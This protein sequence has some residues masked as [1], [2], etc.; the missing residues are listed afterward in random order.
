MKKELQDQLKAYS[1]AASTV[2]ATGLTANAQIVYNSVNATIG[3]NDLDSVDFNMDGIYDFSMSVDSFSSYNVN[4]VYGA[5]LNSQGHALAGAQLGTS[6]TYYNYPFKLAAGDPIKTQ[7]F[8]SANSG[9]SFLFVYNGA[10]PFNSYWKG[11]VVDGYLGIKLNFGGN[12]H[13][14]WARMDIDASGTQ[15]VIKDVA[16]E[17]TPDKNINAG[18]NGLNLNKFALLAKKMWISNKSLF[19]DFDAELS[20]GQI[21]ICDMSGKVLK[22][23]M[24]SQGKNEYDVSDLP[25]GAYVL[26]FNTEDNSVN[27]KVVID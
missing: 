11:G 22:S 21:N 24:L 1:A 10:T 14:G 5:P 8:T 16:Y 13:Y 2:L 6:S 19:T 23:F 12:T 15:V 25:S 18:E 7:N 27:K 26:N 3:I 9:G 17:A 20:T 4:I